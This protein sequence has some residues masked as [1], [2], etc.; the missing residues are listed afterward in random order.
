MAK[1]KKKKRVW[2]I[3]NIIIILL[4][5]LSIIGLFYYALKMPI[6]NIYIKGNNIISD[7]E[8]INIT[9]LYE[10]PSF[11]L[12]KKSNLETKLEKNDYIKKA[13]IKKKFGNVLEITITENTPIA[14]T[15]DG[16]LLLSTGKL[17]ENTYELMDVPILINSIDNSEV[18][19]SFTKKFSKINSNILRQ[20]SQIEYSPVN[21]DEERFL[22]YM[23]DSNLVYITLTKINKLNKYDRIK[24]KLEGKTGIIYLDA[25]DYV[26][27]KQET[28]NN[29]PTN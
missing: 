3:K 7:D 15:S 10:Y 17:L 19:K 26:E 13:T 29:Q 22:L 14:L 1:K 11:L 23:N 4:V 16:K 25:G 27:L 18:L 12:T 5:L 6:K 2:K 8:I 24:D 9:S 20:I 21:V 28:T